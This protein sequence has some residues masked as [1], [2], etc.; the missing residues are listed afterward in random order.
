MFFRE[1]NFYI[2]IYLLYVND[3][4]TQRYDTSRA[5]IYS[6]KQTTLLLFTC[7]KNSQILQSNVMNAVR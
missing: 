3:I 6:Q 7:S 4:K 2:K 1:R 5:Y